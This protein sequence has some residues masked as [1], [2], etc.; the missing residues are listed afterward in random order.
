MNKPVILIIIAFFIIMV[1]SLVKTVISNR[2]STAGIAL[3]GIENEINIYSTENMLLREK[4]LRISSLDYI[5]SK[6]ATLGFVKESSSLVL[7]KSLP[8]AVKQ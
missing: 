4:L 1:L 5:A 3:S 8:L 2:L 7:N 6:A